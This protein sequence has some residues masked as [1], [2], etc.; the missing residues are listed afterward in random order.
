MSSKIVNRTGNVIFIYNDTHVLGNRLSVGVHY[1]NKA[2][3]GL[4]K[5]GI[6]SS[7]LQTTHL[8]PPLCWVNSSNLSEDISE[9]ALK[10][11]PCPTASCCDPCA[12]DPA[13]GL[14]QEL[15]AQGPVCLPSC[16]SVKRKLAGEPCG[17]PSR[18]RAPC[19]RG[20]L[21]RGYPEISH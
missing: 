8:D 12:K 9:L 15:Q 18:Q 6:C 16:R 7:P 5:S 4:G 20:S 3:T 21:G 11:Y 14:S 17:A 1:W 10:A 19:S 13:F 2:G